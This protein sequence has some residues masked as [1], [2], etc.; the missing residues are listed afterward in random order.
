MDP[1]LDE[2]NIH[3]PFIYVLLVTRSKRNFD[4]SY[5]YLFILSSNY[6][7]LWFCSDRLY[8]DQY[9]LAKEAGHVGHHNLSFPIKLRK[10]LT[11]Q[12]TPKLC[13]VGCIE[14]F[15]MGEVILVIYRHVTCII[16]LCFP[17][18]NTCLLIK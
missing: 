6:A 13:Q 2:N 9:K 15:C 17:N 7:Y 16:I 5:S 4:N 12:V 11:R 18:I 14:T 10:Q 8:I 3:L 1:I